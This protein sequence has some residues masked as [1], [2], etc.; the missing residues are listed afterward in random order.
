MKII[1]IEQRSDEWIDW[2]KGKI[3]GTKLGK[4]Y[5]PRGGVKKGYYELIAERIAEAAGDEK[6]ID[7][8]VRLEDDAVARFEVDYGKKVDQVGLVVSDINENIILSP[9]GLIKN[10]DKYTEAI[11]IKCLDSA[12]HIKAMLDD[13]VPKDYELQVLQYFIVIEDLEKL[14]FTFYDDRLPDGHDLH[15]I[16]VFREDLEDRIAEMTQWQI[17]YLGHLDEVVEG[18][19]F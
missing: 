3:S 18:L 10:G 5:S 17:D 12:N 7:R 15:V 11:E 14:Y 2:R 6:P 16:E 8:G 13:E 19:M 9:D 4:I 1:N